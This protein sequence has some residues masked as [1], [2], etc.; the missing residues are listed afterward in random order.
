M[1]NPL[2]GAIK[3]GA[4]HLPGELQIQDVPDF[5]VAHG[6]RNPTFPFL[7]LDPTLIRILMFQPRGTVVAT[8]EQVRVQDRPRMTA[9]MTGFL[10]RAQYLN[11]DLALCPEYACT[12]DALC[13]SIE[14]GLLPAHGK[15]WALACESATPAQLDA[16]LARMSSKVRVLFDGAVLTASGNFVDTLC[17]LFRSPGDAD[18]VDVPV[19]LIQAKTQPMGGHPFEL[20]HLK[21]GRALYRFKNSTQQGNT[22]IGLLCS[23]TLHPRFDAIIPQI[24]TDTLVIHLQMNPNPSSPAFRKYRG[25]CCTNTPRTAEILCLNWARGTT[26]LE[27]GHEIPLIDEPKTILF[28]DR[29]QLMDDDARVMEN[30][31]KGCYLTNWHTHRSAAFVFS[32]DP[33]LFYLETTKPSLAGPAVTTLRTGPR[34][35]EL[36]SWQATIAEWQVGA[37]DDRFE[38]Y[39][40]QPYPELQP[41]LGPL[42]PRYLDAER[43]VQFCT[44]SA[45]AAMDWASSWKLVSYELADDDTTRRLTLCWTTAGE[46]LTFRQRCLSR[47]RSFVGVV[48]HPAQ[49]SSRLDAFRSGGF[50]VEYRGDPLFNRLRNLYKPEQSSATGIYAGEAPPVQILLELKKRIMEGL[51]QTTSDTQLLAI[52]YRDPLGV[53]HDYMDEEI[54]QINEDPFEEPVAIDSTKS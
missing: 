7:T 4:V 24:R 25:D 11:V 3:G 30:H 12:W 13:E 8:S 28:R 18:T 19:A 36:F 42:L 31:A 35:V 49:F 26:L 44:G 48:S 1:K 52:W 39:W 43:L 20:H 14:A 40:L 17:Y 29:Q 47:F 51:Y 27:N 33:H 5:L 45:V 54:P 6:L 16:A 2:T 46:G 9:Q 23:D 22:L 50:T 15:L 10:Q 34:M 32:P 41:L 37:A 53:L 38:S 21:T